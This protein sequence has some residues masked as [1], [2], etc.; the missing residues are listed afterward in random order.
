[1]SEEDCDRL[2]DLSGAAF[3]LDSARW[4]FD[5]RLAALEA[6]N[7]EAKALLREIHPDRD[8]DPEYQLGPWRFAYILETWFDRREALLGPNPE[9]KETADGD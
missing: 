5:R 6:E 8:F 1:V 9:P 2:R 3:T 4:Y 7:A